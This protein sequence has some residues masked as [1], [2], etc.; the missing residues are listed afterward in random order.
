[1][2]G[3]KH[4]PQRVIRCENLDNRHAVREKGSYIHFVQAICGVQ[5]F[6]LAGRRILAPEAG[7]LV[8][9]W[10]LTCFFWH[11]ISDLTLRCNIVSTTRLCFLG[12]DWK[13][14]T[15]VLEDIH[16]PLNVSRTRTRTVNLSSVNE[17]NRIP[18]LVFRRATA[19]WVPIEDKLTRC[20]QG[21]DIK[22]SESPQYKA[23]S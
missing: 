7:K 5:D 22:A 21:C 20:L 2:L 1:M 23:T 12:C 18:V 15:A 4:C 19:S 16:G 8:R 10:T 17:A 13:R 3:D 6:C 9:I 11:P 14:G